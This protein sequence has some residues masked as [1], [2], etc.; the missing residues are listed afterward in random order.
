MSVSQIFAFGADRRLDRDEEIRLIALA[1][2]GDE[3]AK[4]TLLETYAPALRSAV[5]RFTRDGAIDVEEAQ[6]TALLGFVEVL[7]DHDA[8]KGDRLA[9]RLTQ[10]VTRDLAEATSTTT[11][12]AIPERTLSRFYGILRAHDGD[13]SA[14]RDHA[15]SKGMS[16]EVF[17]AV[18]RAIR[19]TEALDAVAADED[20]ERYEV[21]S[22][23]LWENEDP[24]IAVEDA[25][26]VEAAFDAVEKPEA[27]ICEL[28]YGF[29]DFPRSDGEI[30]AVMVSTRPTV[31]RRRERA[32]RTMRVALGDLDAPTEA[33]PFRPSR[34]LREWVV[35]RDLG[36]CGICRKPVE[37]HAETT[38]PRAPEL[39]HVTPQSDFRPGEEEIRDAVSNLRL[40]HRACNRA[41]SGGSKRKTDE[42]V[43]RLDLI[44][45]VR[46]CA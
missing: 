28:A 14:A 6:A 34:A 19:E 25:I 8:G 42:E 20:D 12:F 3:G 30:A 41:K 35:Q 9:G 2:D 17:D 26:L 31:Q 7:A 18:Y 36:V 27:Q 1:Q 37:A 44:P 46:A 38:D 15:R 29:T 39:D 22:F 43:R 16:L 10:R 33:A 23:S 5:G 4:E 45:D 32:L 13:V 24:E 40:T 11:A 21:A